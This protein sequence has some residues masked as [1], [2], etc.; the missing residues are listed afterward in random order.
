MGSCTGFC[1]DLKE[2][3]SFS[4]AM[5]LLDPHFPN[6]GY[7]MGNVQIDKIN[8]GDPND[9]Q[10]DNGQNNDQGLVGF[11]YGMIVLKGQKIKFGSILSYRKEIF[12]YDTF[13]FML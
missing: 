12:G 10:S 2:Q 5:D 13:Q 6:P 7:G 11:L 3:R 8:D 4:G 1:H 9:S